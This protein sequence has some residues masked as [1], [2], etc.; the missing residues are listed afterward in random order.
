MI[1]IGLI[2]YGYW[3]PNLA[4][5]FHFNKDLELTAICDLSSDCLKAACKL[6]PQIDCFDN[7][8]DFFANTDVDAVAIATPVATHFELA[9]R[10]IESGRHLWLDR[11]MTE[12][13]EQGSALIKLAKK[14]K[15]APR[16]SHLRLHWS[17]PQDQGL[18]PKG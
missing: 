9:K 7:V 13:V 8:D 5:N 14:K 17:G 1:K 15:G 16:R 4:R 2:G 11:P 18:D 3:G 10:A 12:T 6:Y